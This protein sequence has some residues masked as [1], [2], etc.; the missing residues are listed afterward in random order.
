MSYLL[1]IIKSAFFIFSRNKLRTF[2]TSL[3]ILIGVMSV[4]LLMAFGLGLKKYIQDQFESLGAN[5]IFVMP[6]NKKTMLKGGII[7]GQKFDEK[8]AMKIRKIKTV[9]VVAPAFVKPGAII[10]VNEKAEIVEIIASTE[11]IVPVFN[12][13]LEQGRTIEK[14]DSQKTNKI[15]LLSKTLAEK[16]FPSSKDAL[17]ENVKMA[18]QNY[19]VIGII[20]SKGGGGIGGA[21]LDDHVYIPYRAAYTFNPDKKFHGIYLKTK[22]Q[23]TVAQTKEE[24]IQVL[25]KRYNE[26]DFSVLEQKEIMNTIS[27][28]FSIINTVLVAIAAISLIVG[29]IGIMNIMY[30]TVTERIRE[31]GIRRAVGA[32]KG[33]ILYQFLGESVLLSIFGGLF[34]L[35]LAEIA[36]FFIKS[37]FPAYID[38]TSIVIALLVSSSIGI[39]FGVF[40]A[41]KAAELTPVEAIRYE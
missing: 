5:L 7:G 12:L 26:D 37:F 2:L 31:I 9:T 17:G 29:G 36:V 20:K 28:I 32:T 3:G 24:I 4:V 21:G 10:E 39:F 13:E 30:V 11:E 41:K 38:Y 33:D 14:K 8:D 27:S 40:P 15:I 35:I 22:N 19:K 18:K 34:G 16:L 1:F 6:G 25:K 23:E